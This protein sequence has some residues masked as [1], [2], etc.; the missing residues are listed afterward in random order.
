MLIITSPIG[1]LV[2]CA[3]G[4]ACVINYRSSVRCSSTHAC[5]A[6]VTAAAG[7]SRS[8]KQLNLTC[9]EQRGLCRLASLLQQSCAQCLQC[10]GSIY[11]HSSTATCQPRCRTPD[12]SKS[13]PAASLATDSCCAA[14]GALW[15]QPCGTARADALLQTLSCC[16]GNAGHGDA[17][18]SVETNVW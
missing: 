6:L 16:R 1:K 17:C 14:Q 15:N 13:G 3:D 4:S 10:R 18:L 8:S 12:D 11:G 5:S 9:Y 2:S 7:P